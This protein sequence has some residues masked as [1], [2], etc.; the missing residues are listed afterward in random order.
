MDH[1]FTEMKE[2]L[3]NLAYLEESANEEGSVNSDTEKETDKA[4]NKDSA[5]TNNQHL[6]GSSN[7]NNVNNWLMLT[8]NTNPPDP[9]S[10]KEENSTLAGIASNLKLGQKKAP[11]VNAQFAGIMKGHACQT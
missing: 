6:S 3:G 7:A 9:K 5:S 11:A 1:S 10:F 8:N 4:P 2:T